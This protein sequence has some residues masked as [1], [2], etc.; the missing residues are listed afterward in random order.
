M[1]SSSSEQTFRPN[2]AEPAANVLVHERVKRLLNFPTSVRELSVKLCKMF[3]LQADVPHLLGYTRYV[4]HLKKPP[5]LAA[6]ILVSSIVPI[7]IES[8][9]LSLFC[10][11]AGNGMAP[12]L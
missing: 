7:G 5:E 11:L 3:A 10:R 12:L 8:G 1:S 6:D 9:L 2:V 4:D